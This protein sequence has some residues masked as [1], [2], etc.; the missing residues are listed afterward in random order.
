MTFLGLD[1]GQILALAL[2]DG[3]VLNQLKLGV[4]SGESDLDRIVDVD[5]RMLIYDDIFFATAYQGRAI[6]LD[7]R[8]Q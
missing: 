2:D 8:G 7:L 5:G 4:S 1:D 3:K 6:A